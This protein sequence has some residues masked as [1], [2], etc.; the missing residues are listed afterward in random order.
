MKFLRVVPVGEGYRGT[1]LNLAARLCAEAGAGQVLA[2]QRVAA[3]VEA[4]A[5]IETLQPLTLRGFHRPVPACRILA[6][7]S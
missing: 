7:K 4:L 3:S 5:E 6:L 2:S 1:A